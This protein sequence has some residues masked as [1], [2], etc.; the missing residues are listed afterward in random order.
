VGGEITIVGGEMTGSCAISLT[1]GCHY[2][3]VIAVVSIWL[4]VSW[5]SVCGC[6]KVCGSYLDNNIW[7]AV[8]LLVNIWLSE[9]GS[10][11]WFVQS[12]FRCIKSISRSAFSPSF[13]RGEYRRR[14][15]YRLG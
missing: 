11:V 9:C 3:V 10:F 12:F 5:L 4:S 15:H 8:L 2:S 13:D 1:A 6:Q 14:A 7:L